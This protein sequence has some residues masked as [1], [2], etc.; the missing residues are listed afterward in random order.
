MAIASA[1][2]IDVHAHDVDH[3]ASAGSGYKRFDWWEETRREWRWLRVLMYSMPP[4]RYQVILLVTV[5]GV[6]VRPAGLMDASPKVLRSMEGAPNIHD[7]LTRYMITP[8][9]GKLLMGQLILQQLHS[10]LPMICRS[11]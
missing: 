5:A 4:L 1:G 7:R 11:W 9:G 8:H 6:G 2:T 3:A 10:S